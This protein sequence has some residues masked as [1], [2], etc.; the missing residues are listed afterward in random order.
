VIRKKVMTKQ[1]IIKK[2]RLFYYHNTNKHAG[3][4]LTRMVKNGSLTR[5]SRG[6]YK[7]GSGAQKGLKYEAPPN[8]LKLF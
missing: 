5:I 2:A 4:V 6:N 1:E 8:Q 7:L 3:D